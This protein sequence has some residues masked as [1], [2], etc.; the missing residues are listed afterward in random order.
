M[1]IFIP[2]KNPIR[3]YKHGHKTADGGSREYHCYNAMRA[4]C[5]NPKNPNFPRYGGRGIS[6][7]ERWRLSFTA[8]LEDMG[9]CPSNGHSI[10][11]IDNDGD[12]HPGNCRWADATQQA[13]NRRSSRLISHD[14]VTMS[15]AEWSRHKGIGVSTIHA[16]LKNGWSIKRS[17]EERVR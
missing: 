15:L 6:V 9:R 4:R 7:C 12:Y 13:N 8:F 11:R 14:G 2:P 3:R 5:H 1:D 16:R 17:L 10:D